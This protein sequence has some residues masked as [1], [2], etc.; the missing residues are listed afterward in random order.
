MA[1]MT[2][3]PLVLL[4]AQRAGP[5]TGMPTKP[6]QSDLEHVLYTSQGDGTRFVVSPGNNSEAYEQTRL[7]FQIA[8][9]YHLPSII[10]TDQKISGEFRTVPESVFDTD[11]NAGEIESVLSEKE[12]DDRPH[13]S[14]GKFNRYQYIENLEGK[15]VSPR[16]VPGQK[17]GRFLATG[18]EHNPQGHISEDSENREKQVDRR[19]KKLE[20]I[21]TDIE[22]SDVSLQKTFG[23]DDATV[24]IITFGSQQGTVRDV[25]ENSS[26]D[27][28]GM[29]VSQLKPFPVDDVQSF[30]DDLRVCIVV[31]MNAT[32]QFM[33]E[34]KR[35]VETRRRPQDITLIPL[36]RYDGNPV[37]RHEISDE[38]T[39]VIKNE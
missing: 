11:S 37:R 12:I 3:T 35:N 31:E 32:G 33:N 8:Y 25:V 13:H 10:L 21:R 15:S 14:S 39:E 28:K 26:Y 5:S 2:E 29:G 20:D 24:G 30:L 7:A 16:T 38:I 19:M 22:E 9:R 1:E 17:N 36:R 23:L 18:N 4:E 27:V 6:E 34:L